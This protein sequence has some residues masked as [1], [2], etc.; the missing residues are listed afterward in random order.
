MSFMCGIPS[1]CLLGTEEDWS[2][3]LTRIQ[4]LSEGK[5]GNE[6]RHWG[7]TL[8]IVLS[9]FVA[10]FQNPGGDQPFW[11]SI[12]RFSKEENLIGGWITAFARWGPPSDNGYE[13]PLDL[14]VD[15]VKGAPH[16][17]SGG[18]KFPV[19]LPSRIPSSLGTIDLHLVEDGR[20]ITAR[21]VAGHLGKTWLGVKSDTLQPCSAW[22]LYIPKP[23]STSSPQVEA[24]SAADKMRRVANSIMKSKKEKDEQVGS[25]WRNLIAGASQSRKN[26]VT[27]L[28]NSRS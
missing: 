23:P 26:G 15:D 25:R 7:Q 10:A 1:L 3:I 12:V 6:A 20:D 13:V 22:L 28:P 24:E 2:D 14:P 8:V 4:P 11:E 27:E 19:V 21:L 18:L 16:F 5:Y 9:K 17:I